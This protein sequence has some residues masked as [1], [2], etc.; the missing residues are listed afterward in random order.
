MYQYATITRGETQPRPARVIVVDREDS[1]NVL[2][3]PPLPATDE[4][5]GHSQSPL[6]E[7]CS[8]SLGGRVHAQW[9]SGYDKMPLHSK[10]K[11]PPRVPPAI[12]D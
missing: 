3:E 6:W 1:H 7:Q 2:F 9:S 5:I 12:L 4:A 8:I 11:S 10:C